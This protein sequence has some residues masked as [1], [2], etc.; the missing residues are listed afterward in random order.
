MKL[1]ISGFD[2]NSDATTFDTENRKDNAPNS[3]FWLKNSKDNAPIALKYH[4]PY[5]YFM[6]KC[7]SH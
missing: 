5:K 1:K 4:P 2:W 6:F 7:H 3:I